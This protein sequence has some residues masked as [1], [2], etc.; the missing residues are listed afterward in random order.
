MGLIATSK[1]YPPIEAGTHRAVCIAVIDLG[2]QY[3]E[4]YAKYSHKVVIAWELPEIRIDI[5]KD[6]ETKNLPRVISKT[7][8]VSTHEK[9]NFTKDLTSWRGRPFTKE[10]RDN[11]Y[12]FKVLSANC[13]LQVI[14]NKKNKNNV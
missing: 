4:Y 10:E 2:T 8:V 11:F 14:H 1:S 13:L 5:E 3:S 12:I 9:A 7:Y 6:G